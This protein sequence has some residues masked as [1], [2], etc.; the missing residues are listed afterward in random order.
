MHTSLFHK[1]SAYSE[2][3]FSCSGDIRKERTV[4]ILAVSIYMDFL[5]E[6]HFLVS[7]N[8]E[9]AFILLLF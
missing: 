4:I 2:R 8:A 7:A 9:S 6:M 5:Q 1:L 3:L